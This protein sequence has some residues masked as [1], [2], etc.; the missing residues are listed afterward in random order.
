M[1]AG[2][3]APV[4]FPDW[5]HGLCQDSSPTGPMDGLCPR[6]QLG[7]FHWGGCPCS[8]AGSRTGL[9]SHF[10]VHSLSFMV[11]LPGIPPS[12]LVLS[13]TWGSQMLTETSSLSQGV[14]IPGL[15]EILLN[16]QCACPTPSQ[17][18]SEWPWRAPPGHRAG[19]GDPGQLTSLLLAILGK[20][21]SLLGSARLVL[22]EG[23]LAAREDFN[24]CPVSSAGCR[25]QSLKP[26]STPCPGR[27]RYLRS[28]LCLFAA[29]GGPGGVLL[30]PTPGAPTLRALSQTDDSCLHADKSAS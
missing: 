12:Y 10:G 15:G 22:A 8:K 30:P 14:F 5:C 13:W 25:A 19:G 23:F 20:D 3:G 6:T 16:I 2:N 29:A 27:S 9:Q 18:L 7:V 21:A 28:P 17:P 4:P 11:L 1:L 24:A 26:L